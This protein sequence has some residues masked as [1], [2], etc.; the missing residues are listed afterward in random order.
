MASRTVVFTTDRVVGHECLPS[1]KALRR[2]VIAIPIKT[3]DSLTVRGPHNVLWKLR[4][5]PS[6]NQSQGGNNCRTQSTTSAAPTGRPIQQGNSSGTG[7]DQRHNRLYALQA[8][9]DQEDSPDVVT[10]HKIRHRPLIARDEGDIRRRA[11]PYPSFGPS[12]SGTNAPKQNRFY[13]L[14]TRGE[15][16]SSPDV[17]TGMFKVFQLD[18]YDLLDPG[19]TLSFMTLYM[20]MR[21]D[22]LLDPFPVSTP[23]G[24]SVMAQ[25]VYKKCL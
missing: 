22:V 20:A 12:D 18:V 5:C 23:I 15:Q 17:V 3:T 11:Q 9:P 4:N 14:Q 25:R 13:A 1:E 8:H 6:S 2:S 16:E 24:D 19:A 7:G 10:D 21:F